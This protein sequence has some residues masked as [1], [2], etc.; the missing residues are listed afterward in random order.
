MTNKIYKKIL[1]IGPSWLGDSVMSQTMLHLLT[2]QQK[3][4]KIDILTSKCYIPL[5]HNMP[6]INQTIINPIKHGTME[7]KK[8]YTFSKTL[9]N[10]KYQQAIILPNSFK[11]ALI[12]LFAQIPQRTGWRGE[13]RYG[14][15]N[16]LRILNCKN[17]PLMVQ[18]YAALAF[19]KN[20]IKH[21]NNLPKPLPWPSLSISSKKINHILQKFKIYSNKPLIG[22]CPGSGSNSTKC[23]PHYHYAVL[24]SKLMHDGYQI[25]LFGSI[26]DYKI[27]QNIN[28]LI[29][30]KINNYHNLIGSTSIDQVIALLAGCQAIISNDSGL[31][32]IT[33]A[34][35]RPLIVLYGG[36][37][38]PHFT[39]PLSHRAYVIE[40]KN[41]HL[42]TKKQNNINNYHQNLIDIKPDQ[43][44]N[45][46]KKLLTIS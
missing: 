13:M 2:K 34:L 9:R 40:S 26:K 5:F 35:N 45:K 23:W 28:N 42:R 19:N 43:V 32:H 46:L 31:M 18:R 15:I 6:E 12:P 39:P 24:A 8:I 41:K 33:N 22:L 11:S 14:I 3:K 25:A 10:K 30:K 4:I 17:F 16:D 21:S 37:S 27:G 20:I 44:L 38:D 29:L 1:V 36:P 7:L